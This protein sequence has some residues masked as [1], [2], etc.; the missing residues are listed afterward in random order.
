MKKRFTDVDIWNDPW[1]RKLPL[2]MKCFWFYI[3]DTC[4]NAGVWKKDY[5]T[6]EFFIGENINESDISC[7]NERKERVFIADN[8]LI[9]K[10]FIPFQIGDLSK[11]GLTNLQKNCIKLIKHHLSHGIN[12]KT[13]CELTG[14][15]RVSYPKATGIS[16]GKGKGISKGKK[17]YRQF[18]H[19]KITIEDN[20][21][22]LNRGYTQ[23]QIN[24]I[25][26]SIENYKKNTSYV[27]L[28]LTAGKWLKKEKAKQE[29]DDDTPKEF[30]Y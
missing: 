9:I 13:I 16:K 18:A 7:L 28:Y 1:F 22:L 21:K 3:C 2:K 26:D 29:E 17:I 27:S 19:L 15:L 11:E 24:D 23:E 12:L 14:K 8:Y 30:D 4:D 5:E 6:A 20:Q 10:E 25:Y